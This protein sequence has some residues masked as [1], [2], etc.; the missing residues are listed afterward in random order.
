M[1][2]SKYIAVGISVVVLVWILSGIFSSGSGENGKE[3]EVGTASAT[4]VAEVRV[5][6][7]VAQSYANDPQ[8][9]QKF[10][11]GIS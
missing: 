5:R 11:S 4:K 10:V 9:W 6:D 8:K 2:S 3:P 7:I 1:K